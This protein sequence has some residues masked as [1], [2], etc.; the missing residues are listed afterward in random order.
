MLY[1]TGAQYFYCDDFIGR[2]RG[3]F[4]PGRPYQTYT[5]TNP[6]TS[7]SRLLAAMHLQPIN[8]A[9][10]VQRLN[11]LAQNIKA[12]QEL[13][14]SKGGN[15]INFGKSKTYAVLAAKVIAYLT[16]NS[17]KIELSSGAEPDWVVYSDIEFEVALFILRLDE[18]PP[19]VKPSWWDSA[20]NYYFRDRGD[21]DY[22]FI[23]YTH[24][25]K[26]SNINFSRTP[27]CDPLINDQANA[28]AKEISDR[29]EAK[30]VRE[31]NAAE[32]QWNDPH[33]VEDM[34]HASRDR[35]MQSLVNEE[36]GE[37]EF[38]LALA[39]WDQRNRRK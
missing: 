18:A 2:I 3:D 38:S 35:F 19:A 8:E 21:L 10:A 13:D 25:S 20:A 32:M 16:G 12:N 31:E 37:E 7:E 11:N 26:A 33:F 1:Q 15:P 9:L 6:I 36:L 23:T 27:G 29:Y 4:D 14:Q 28:W 34:F 22:D 39:E 17:V 30:I 24:A 5:I